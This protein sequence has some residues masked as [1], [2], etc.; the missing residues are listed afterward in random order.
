M[1]INYYTFRA[2]ADLIDL[3]LNN[4]SDS[5]ESELDELP[6]VSISLASTSTVTDSK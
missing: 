2:Y 1:T 6:N 5:D 4:S 3:T